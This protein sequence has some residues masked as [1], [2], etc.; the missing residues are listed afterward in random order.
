MRGERARF[1]GVAMVCLAAICA[2]PAWSQ[3]LRPIETS[4]AANATVAPPANSYRLRFSA[5]VNHYESRLIV[6]QGGQVLETLRPRL[7]TA[8]DVV[9][10]ESRP[11]QPGAYELRWSVR[12]GVDS[13]ISEGALAFTVR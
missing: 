11:L 3:G 12:S 4:P 9:F 2:A 7:E 5:P 10:A 1:I 8:P 13:S 6:L